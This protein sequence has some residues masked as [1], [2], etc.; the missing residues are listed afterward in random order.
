LAL[1]TAILSS[2][3]STPMANYQLFGVE[4]LRDISKIRAFCAFDRATVDVACG[5][6]YSTPRVSHSAYLHKIVI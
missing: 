3:A 2:L 6:P 5:K 1:S 4:L